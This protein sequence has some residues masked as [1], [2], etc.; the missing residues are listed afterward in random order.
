MAIGVHAYRRTKGRGFNGNKEDGNEIKQ[1]KTKGNMASANKKA[2]RIQVPVICGRSTMAKEPARAR[3]LCAVLSLALPVTFGHTTACH[4]PVLSFSAAIY[5]AMKHP[6]PC[7]TVVRNFP[8]SCAGFVHCLTL[9]PKAFKAYW[10]VQSII[11]CHCM[12]VCMV[13]TYSRVW[14]NRVRLPILLVVS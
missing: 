1:R 5:F 8:S 2:Q 9:I 4:S 11:V 3:L 7:S 14:I 10:C 6:A 12:Y 13:I